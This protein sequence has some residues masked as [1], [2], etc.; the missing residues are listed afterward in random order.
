M[1]EEALDDQVVLQVR[2]RAVL[3]EH[4]EVELQQTLSVRGPSPSYDHDHRCG[5]CDG[6][7]AGQI[8]RDV[9]RSP[10]KKQGNRV[11]LF[12]SS[13]VGVLAIATRTMTMCDDVA[14]VA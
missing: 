2:L 10:A 6:P 11:S 3:D 5:G 8:T 13:L 9:S 7:H 1:E 14:W 4:V 12:H